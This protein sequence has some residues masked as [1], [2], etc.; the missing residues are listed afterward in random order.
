MFNNQKKYIYLSF[1][2]PGRLFFLNFLWTTVEFARFPVRFLGYSTYFVFKKFHNLV[3][4]YDLQA[5][6]A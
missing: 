6:W 2:Q 1:R 4:K 3:E 5:Y